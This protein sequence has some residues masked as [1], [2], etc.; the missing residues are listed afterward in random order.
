V[1][2]P[3]PIGP[4]RPS[5]FEAPGVPEE[6]PEAPDTGSDVVLVESTE[7]I[8]AAHARLGSEALARLRGRYADV[9]ANL[10][11]RVPDDERR[12]QLREQAERLNPD[13]WVTDAEVTAGLE[14]YESVLASLRE[15]VAR[16]RRRRRG[17]GGSAQ[18]GASADAQGQGEF[19][20]S[21]G[22]QDGAEPAGEHRDGETDGDPLSDD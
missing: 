13:N 14:A 20:D 11:R 19:A 6:R 16:R 7:P 21:E 10:A 8:S 12:Q 3:A 17:R 4:E 15:V 5:A 22:G 9:L 1:R 18:T 2:E